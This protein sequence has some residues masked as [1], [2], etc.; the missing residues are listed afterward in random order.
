M[1]PITAWRN[2]SD[3]AAAQGIPSLDVARTSTGRAEVGPREIS[4]DRLPRHRLLF[5]RFRQI[6]RGHV[7]DSTESLGKLAVFAGV[8]GLP[9]RIKR[10]T[11][12]WHTLQAALQGKQVALTE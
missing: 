8:A 3:T 12:A 9:T 5:G 2:W 10:A 1:M 11:L 7:T 4:P 6:V